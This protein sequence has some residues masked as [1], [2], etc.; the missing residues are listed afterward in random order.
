MIKEIRKLLRE[1]I[2]ELLTRPKNTYDKGTEHT[3]YKAEHN[4]DTLYKT[5]KKDRIIYCYKLFKKYPELF[6]IVYRTGKIGKHE[7]YMEV[8]KLD[9]KRVQDDWEH[10]KDKL[11]V[12]DLFDIFFYIIEY[13]TE[14]KVVYKNTIKR[15][16]DDKVGLDIFNR[17][18]NL[19]KAIHKIYNTTI[20]VHFGNFGYDKDGKLKCLDP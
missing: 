12:R 11:E 3:I 7:A 20:D 18:V 1:H 16:A 17:W 5:G 8:E 13:K 10:L 4:P 15:L 19:L 2:D 9:T 14:G 6:P